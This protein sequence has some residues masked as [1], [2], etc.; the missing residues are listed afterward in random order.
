MSIG[1]A[2]REGSF[3]GRLI[4]YLYFYIPLTLAFIWLLI[5]SGFNVGQVFGNEDLGTVIET[6]C[7]F[8]TMIPFVFWEV[9]IRADR[10]EKNLPIYKNIAKDLKE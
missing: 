5:M 7:L 8:I 6:L 10:K 1:K 2:I 4:G 9:A 3:K